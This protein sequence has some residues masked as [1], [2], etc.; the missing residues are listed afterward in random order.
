MSEIEI[1]GLTY[2]VGKMD[3]RKQFH[4]ARRL[5]PVLGAIMTHLP[6]AKTA[7]NGEAET[8]EAPAMDDQLAVLGPMATVV[9][10][11]PDADVDYILAAC[12]A[13]C[14]RQ[15]PGGTGWSN[16]QAANGA[17]MFSDIDMPTMLQLVWVVIQ[18]NLSGFSFA[19]A[20][21]SGASAGQPGA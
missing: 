8:P 7:A 10:A 20:L 1:K 18:D 13:V 15:N 4:V 16:I 14:A 11:M 2:R 21:T 3:P 19:G 6:A 17:L 5:T 9:A 12:L